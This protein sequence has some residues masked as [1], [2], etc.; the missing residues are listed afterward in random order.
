[1]QMHEQVKEQKQDISQKQ[2]QDMTG[3]P[4]VDSAVE[5]AIE[6]KRHQLISWPNN[7]SSR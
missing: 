3:K 7:Q 2:K 6:K 4:A 5:P 1:M